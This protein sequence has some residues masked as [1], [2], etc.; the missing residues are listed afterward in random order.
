MLLHFKKILP[1]LGNVVDLAEIHFTHRASD[2][3]S[4]VQM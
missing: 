3:F 4:L 2:W 1:F